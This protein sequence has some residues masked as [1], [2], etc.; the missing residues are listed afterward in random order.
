MVSIKT[1]QKSMRF[2]IILDLLVKGFWSEVGEIQH[3]PQDRIKDGIVGALTKPD[4]RS[5]K[6]RTA[7]N[8][9]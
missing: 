9:K 1:L 6:Q 5:I 2:L 4:R 8:S 7:V 3:L